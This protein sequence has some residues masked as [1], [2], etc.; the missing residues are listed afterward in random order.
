M[1][2]SE[3]DQ[4]IGKRAILNGDGDLAFNGEFRGAI[5]TKVEMRI[6]K[7][8]KGGKVYLKD[9]WGVFYSVPAK[10]VGIIEEPD[11]GMIKKKPLSGLSKADYDMMIVMG[12]MWEVYPE[13]TGDFEKDCGIR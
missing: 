9:D 2:I 6:I 13:C 7:K 3:I 8:T 1:K 4:N 5:F 11:Y 12:M 10:N